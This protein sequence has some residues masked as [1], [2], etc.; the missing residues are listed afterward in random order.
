MEEIK[1]TN[2]ELSIKTEQLLN[3]TKKDI[4][5]L[6]SGAVSAV[7]NG[8]SDKMKSY[9]YAKKIESLG[10]ELVKQ[11]KPYADDTTVQ[12][13]GLVQY[14]ASI[15]Q[16]EQGVSYDYATTGDKEWEAL[17]QLLEDTKLKKEQRE[18]FL[19]TVLVPFEYTNH[20]TGE[21]YTI[22]PPVK[23]G[24]LGISVKLK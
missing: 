18:A 8:T 11:L 5:D 16:S 23:S 21:T 19:K 14:S 12:K 1:E 7:K 2:Q 13:G 10:K 17:N 3:A 22:S 4:S 24:K 15:T 6:V 20:E 9:I